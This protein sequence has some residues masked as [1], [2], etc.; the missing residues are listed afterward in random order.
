LHKTRLMSDK[1]AR[2]IGKEPK[3]PERLEH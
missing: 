3:L 2:G 1:K